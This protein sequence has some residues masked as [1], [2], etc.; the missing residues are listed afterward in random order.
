MSKEEKFFR[1][2]YLEKSEIIFIC[3]EV[4]LKIPNGKG[5]KTIGLFK[6]DKKLDTFMYD[7]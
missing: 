1:I 5:M 4:V 3:S 2:Y 7:Y 6:T